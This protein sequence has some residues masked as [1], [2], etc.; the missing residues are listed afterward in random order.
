M[1]GFSL[2]EAIVSLAILAAVGMALFAAMGQSVRMVAKAE[3]ARTRESALRDALA[4]MQTVNPALAPEGRQQLGEV[5]LHWT[6]EPLEP[7]RDAA[8]GYT[9]A[10]LYQVGLYQMHL[11][12]DRDGRPFAELELRRVGY[13]QVR[14]PATL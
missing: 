3:E 4:W 7:P 14:E 8:T 2:L 6:S 5:V 12:L 1:A 13:R 11:Q 10:G 9:Q